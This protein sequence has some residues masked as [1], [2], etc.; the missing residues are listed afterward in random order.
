M[1]G[2]LRVN[3]DSVFR[4]TENTGIFIIILHKQCNYFRKREVVYLE[5]ITVIQMM[6]VY[7]FWLRLIEETAERGWKT[8]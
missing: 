8:K 5:M 1:S 3:H 2:M 6:H 7:S 4:L